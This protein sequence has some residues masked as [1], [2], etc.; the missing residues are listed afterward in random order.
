MSSIFQNQVVIITGASSGIG[1]A[2]ALSLAGQGAKLSLAARNETALLSIQEKCTQK[3]ADTL[4]IPT[5]VSDQT[6]CRQLIDKTVE[7]FGQ[8][9]MLINNAGMT[10]YTRFEDI[11]N[12]DAFEQIVKVKLFGSM[13]CTYY[14]L[15]YLKKN[16]GRIVGIS[17]LT[18]KTG[19]PTRTVYAASNHAMA[20][21]FDSL[22][23]ELAESGVTITMIYPGFV[24]TPIRYK[25][26]NKIGKESGESHIS[27]K[28]AMPVERCVEIILEAAQFR[29]RE[30]IMTWQGK[31]GQ[32]LKLIAPQIVD[33]VTSKEVNFS[34]MMKKISA[35]NDNQG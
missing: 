33:W 14:A 7:K 32:W 12:F 29:R 5:D 2:I 9:D 21:F 3:G 18:G 34:N 11:E 15:P 13:Y 4:V 30:V 19:V 17:S 24:E 20:G 26:L 1:E 6:M 35:R 8:I 23:I 22:R 10:M 28:K 27:E 31:A 25:A 16:K